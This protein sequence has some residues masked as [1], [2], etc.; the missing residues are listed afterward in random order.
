MSTTTAPPVGA[1]PAQA[2]APERR[3]PVAFFL[4]S[5]SVAV[6][7]LWLYLTTYIILLGAEINAETERQTLKDTTTGPEQPIG[8]RGAEAAD[9]KASDAETAKGARR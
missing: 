4:L 1:F 5:P 8:S 3:R 7:L 9:S 6:L 2:E